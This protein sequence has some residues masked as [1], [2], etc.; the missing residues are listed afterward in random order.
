GDPGLL[1][2]PAQGRQLGGRGGQDGHDDLRDTGPPAAGC[3]G[4]VG[5]EGRSARGARGRA[6]DG[7]GV[8]DQPTRS[9]R[10]EH[11]DTTWR[12]A[13]NFVDRPRSSKQVRI[14][15]GTCRETALSIRSTG[16]F[17]GSSSKTL[18]SPT[19]SSPPGS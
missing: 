10:V 2:C 11:E 9:G 3:I 14:A 6:E 19:R 5:P 16:A 1:R 18:R 13:S 17:Y 8:R 4:Q 12:H 15:S 7:G